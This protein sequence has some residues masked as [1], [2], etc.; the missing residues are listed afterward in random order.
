LLRFWFLD[1]AT[2]MLPNLNH[3][4]MIKGIDT[5]RGTGIID[6][7][8]LP[9]LLDAIGFLRLSKSWMV[10]DETGIKQ[11]FAEYL[12]WM[13]TSKNGIKESQVTNNHKTFYE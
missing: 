4:Q 7:H 3:A 10:T 11:W 13:M 5:G 6:T 2:R 1:T 12:N 9:K 8:E